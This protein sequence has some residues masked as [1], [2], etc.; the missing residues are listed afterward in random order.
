MVTIRPKMASSKVITKTMRPP[1]TVTMTI[2]MAPSKLRYQATTKIMRP[3]P[4]ETTTTKM[5]SNK[6]RYQATT[7]KTNEKNSYNLKTVARNHWSSPTTKMAAIT[8]TPK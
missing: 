1:S 6:L 3:Q 5:A 4:T 7:M 8:E 2:K